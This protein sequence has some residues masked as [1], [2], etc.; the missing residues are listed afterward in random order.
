MGRNGKRRLLAIWRSVER[1]LIWSGGSIAPRTPGRRATKCP[2]R[3][4]SCGPSSRGRR[5]PSRTPPARLG[6]Q[7]DCR[8]VGPHQW[9]KYLGL[10]SEVAGSHVGAVS[11]TF[12]DRPLRAG[13]LRPRPR[14]SDFPT[15]TNTPMR[16]STGGTWPRFRWSRIGPT[17]EK[18]GRT[19]SRRRF[20][21]RARGVGLHERPRQG[22]AERRRSGRLRSRGRDRR[23]R[24]SRSAAGGAAIAGSDVRRRGGARQHFGVSYQ[25]ALFR[26]K[27]LSI[28]S[29]AEFSELLKKE[30][31]GKNYLEMLQV[32]NEL[33]G[34]DQRTPDREIVSQVVHLALEAFRR[35]EISQGR[36][37][38]SS[39]L[40]G[41]SAK[42]LLALAE[43][44]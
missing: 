11:Q 41:V 12:V 26:L 13:E 25:A 3:S 44:A 30:T 35:E 2:R 14:G 22:G 21:C 6:A 29:E 1:A 10:G 31:F 28:V 23:R 5:P 17:W 24:A 34:Q 18:C 7:S 39:A 32:L 4:G 27:G 19:L 36:L 20:C 43:A 8:Y 15:L 16:C 42:K 33:D 38:E 40:V 37:R 9:A